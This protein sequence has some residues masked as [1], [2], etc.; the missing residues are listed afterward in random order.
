M[1]KEIVKLEPETMTEG[2]W[3]AVNFVDY[4]EVVRDGARLVVSP[5]MASVHGPAATA[6]MQAILDAS[7]H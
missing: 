4:I 1:A 5:Y 7:A 6:A 3:K 2:A